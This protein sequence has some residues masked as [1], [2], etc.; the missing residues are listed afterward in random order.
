[1]TKAQRT[2][3]PPLSKQSFQPSSKTQIV[4]RIPDRL[5]ELLLHDTWGA[6]DA[7][8]ILLGL[9][10]RGTNVA[11]LS[12][13]FL[14][15]THARTLDGRI[16]IGKENPAAQDELDQFTTAY[17]RIF[18]AWTS[19]THDDRN[20][21]SHYAEWAKRKQIDVSWL[22]EAEA[23]ELIP[24]RKTNVSERS[25]RTYLNIIGALVELLLGKTPSGSRT[26]CSIIRLRSLM[27]FWGVTRKGLGS[28]SGHSK[29][30][31]PRP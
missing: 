11:A 21:P 10:P 30:N 23:L 20:I 25:E 16:V 31:S 13:R 12:E 26:Q 4:D 29:K 8:L 19:G 18:D 2:R 15:V 17:K 9:D 28:A 5:K 14:L 1:V 22:E 6:G 7:L 3:R 24:R 27:Q